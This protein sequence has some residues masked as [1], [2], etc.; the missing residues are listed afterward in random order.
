MND[1]LE[2]S[3]D[4]DLKF[5]PFDIV[6]MYSNVPTN[7]LINIID[8]MCTQDDI[9]EQLKHELKRISQIL[10]KQ[11]YLQFQD[12]LYIQEEGLAM[13]AP[14]SSVFS[15]VYLKQTENTEIVANLL[16]HHIIGYFLYVDDIHSVKTNTTNIHD[17]LKLFNNIMPT[18]KFNM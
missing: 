5:V 16:G 18:T 2:F 11:N 9:K 3:Y 7:E 10:I 1:F 4:Q 8:L 13:G 12:T 6:N 14:T 15:E 17:F